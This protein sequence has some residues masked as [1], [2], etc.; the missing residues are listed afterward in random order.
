[1]AFLPLLPSFS[2][3][4]PSVTCTYL[5]ISPAGC[6]AFGE[7]AAQEA[8]RQLLAVVE[9][10]GDGSAGSG[11]GSSGREAAPHL[12]VADVL[13]IV[14]SQLGSRAEATRLAALAW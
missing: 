12:K 2:A 6:S 3:T 5:Y 14:A 10:S 7:Q 8:N 4:F 9:N 13:L 11:G 1:M